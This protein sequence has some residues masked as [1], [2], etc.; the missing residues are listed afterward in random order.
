MQGCV[1]GAQIYSNPEKMDKL[2]AE[3]I[4]EDFFELYDLNDDG[5]VLF[6]EYYFVNS[7]NKKSSEKAR[8]VF[9][10]LDKVKDW[11][12]TEKEFSKA[13][14]NK[15]AEGD[16]GRKKKKHHGRRRHH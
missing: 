11:R 14:L 3:D 16:A 7:F 12:I 5:G 1:D 10:F 13:K 6:S 9:T 2:A 15:I 4:Q 8:E